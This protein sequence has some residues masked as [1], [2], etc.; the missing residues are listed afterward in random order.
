MSTMLVDIQSHKPYRLSL[1][2]MHTHAVS[3]VLCSWR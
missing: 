1:I 2:G 3:D